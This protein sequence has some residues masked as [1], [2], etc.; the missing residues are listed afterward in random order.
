V[1]FDGVTPLHNLQRAMMFQMDHPRT[2][3]AIEEETVDLL[4]NCTKG[5]DWKLV[6]QCCQKIPKSL[7]SATLQCCSHHPPNVQMLVRT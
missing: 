6:G 2:F 7:G 4:T 1:V 5:G 3:H